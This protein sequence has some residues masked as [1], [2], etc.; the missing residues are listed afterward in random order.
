MSADFLHASLIKENRRLSNR[1][2]LLSKENK[3]LKD[4][5]IKSEDFLEAIKQHMKSIKVSFKPYKKLGK[6]KIKRCL[7]AHISDTHI[8]A[9]I[10]KRNNDGLNHFNYEIACDRFSYFFSQIADYKLQYRKETDLVLVINGD[11]IAGVIHDQEH[12]VELA[13]VQFAQAL[14]I[15]STGIAYLAQNFPNVKV[16]ITTGNHDRFMH[17]ENKGRQTNNKFDSFA[18]ILGTSLLHIF[19]NSKNIEIEVPQTPYARFKV[20]KHKFFATHGDTVLNVGNVGK[21]IKTDNITNSVMKI[22]SGLKDDIDVIMLGHVHVPTYQILGNGT[23]LVINGTLS[24]LD[25]FCINIGIFSNFP[26][27]QFFEVT[28]DHPVGDLRYIDL[29]N[30]PKGFINTI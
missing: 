4:S 10:N 25:D 18:T 3:Y 17:K 27:Q 21:V 26:T 14:N 29:K 5:S 7:V 16:Y 6:S 28:E 20:F 15:F 11:I 23:R 9:I 30:P 19:K 8:G 24:G 1:N 12:G 2:T 22:S 13:S